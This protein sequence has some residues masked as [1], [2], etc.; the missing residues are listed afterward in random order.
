MGI[1]LFM[2]RRERWSKK[3]SMVIPIWNIFLLG[4]GEIKIRSWGTSIIFLT[5]AEGFLWKRVKGKDKHLG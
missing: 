1:Y 3:R 4:E 2:K 5:W